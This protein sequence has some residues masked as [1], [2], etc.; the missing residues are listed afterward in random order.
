MA[1]EAAYLA[2]VPGCGS[3]GC[4][5]ADVAEE[6]GTPGT[7]QAIYAE[8]RAGRCLSVVRNTDGGP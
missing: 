5:H 3:R 4:F 8:C 7:G 6:G 1:A 2:C